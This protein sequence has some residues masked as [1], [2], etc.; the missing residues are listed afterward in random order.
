MSAG[1]ASTTAVVTADT[2]VATNNGVAD[3]LLLM[4]LLLLL[5]LLLVLPLMWCKMQRTITTMGT[6][7]FNIV[8][9]GNIG[10]LKT[11]FR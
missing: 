11:L 9:K 2:I 4:L 3:L 10:F 8:G 7:V 1:V 5:L 6:I